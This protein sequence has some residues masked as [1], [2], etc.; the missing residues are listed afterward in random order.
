[1]EVPPV[2]R[3]NNPPHPGRI[4]RR[5]MDS[6]KLGSGDA[7]AHLG[8]QRAYLSD[9]VAGVDGINAD[10]AV[11]LAKAFGWSPEF[12][13]S[14]QQK[15][16]LAQ[17]DQAAVE[18]E[19]LGADPGGWDEFFAEPGFDL[20]PREQPGALSAVKPEAEIDQRL[21]RLEAARKRIKGEIQAAGLEFERR[22]AEA[23]QRKERG[24]VHVDAAQFDEEK[25]RYPLGRPRR[26]EYGFL[27]VEKGG[28]TKI[29]ILD[30][31][32]C[33]AQGRTL[34]LAKCAA[35]LAIEEWILRERAAG[36][37]IREPRDV[38]DLMGSPEIKRATSAGAFFWYVR[39]NPDA[40]ARQAERAA[41][42]CDPTA[43]D[44][45]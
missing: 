35:T 39:V 31:P 4:V 6:H 38:V 22:E 1:M 29:T 17:I 42:L 33:T 13:L 20:G 9:V 26:N 11:R 24:A 40:P 27:S 3:M 41:L 36:R 15:H 21:V 19:R 37:A 44:R 18:V 2:A 8:V 10:L 32:D 5:Y 12:W 23:R 34:E 25:L 28:I 43:Y 45:L 7:A 14:G 30:V 16:D